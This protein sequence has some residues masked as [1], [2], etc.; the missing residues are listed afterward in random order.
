[1]ANTIE[2]LP[3]EVLINI[4]LYLDTDAARN[5]GRTC[6]RFEEIILD[7]YFTQ[8]A[9]H[10][11]KY[12]RDG[13]TH[14]EQRF[15]NVKDGS[16]KVTHQ[17]TKVCIKEATYFCGYLHGKSLQRSRNGTTI[18]DEMYDQNKLTGERHVKLDYSRILVE[19]Y[20]EGVRDGSLCV[21]Q[22][23][24]LDGQKV[25][26]KLLDGF[27]VDGKRSHRWMYFRPP[28]FAHETNGQRLIATGLFQSNKKIGQWRYKRML[29][30]DV[31]V[32]YYM[33]GV[34]MIAQWHIDQTHHT[35]SITHFQALNILSDHPTTSLETMIDLESVF[36]NK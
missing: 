8:K 28:R 21:W 14:E 31:L 5:C 20:K 25:T 23:M 30:D 6:K 19:N 35:Q 32:G 2:R 12:E 1:M 11:I 33:K 16:I 9:T 3:D 27:Y 24:I 29:E 7:P 15:L 18:I 4:F 13:C 10:T 34:T 36:R 26:F 17:A 22:T